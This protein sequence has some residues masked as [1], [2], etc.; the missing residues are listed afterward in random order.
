VLEHN[1]LTF[2]RTHYL[3]SLLVNVTMAQTL[4]ALGSF[5]LAHKYK[6]RWEVTIAL[7]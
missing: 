3:G 1:L 7:T 4:A 6:V 5:N 2:I